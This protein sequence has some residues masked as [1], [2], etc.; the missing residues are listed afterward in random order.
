MGYQVGKAPGGWV[1]EQSA[2]R[3]RWIWF[4]LVIFVFLMLAMLALAV[5]GA[6]SAVASL[7]LIATLLT[8]RRYVDP[9]LDQ[10][11]RL[12]GGARAEEAVGVTLNELI[13]D[14]WTVMH[15]IEQPREGNVDHLVAGPGG[16][17]MVETK[18]RRY[19]E[20]Q[21]R[22]AKRQAAKIHDQLGVWVTPVICLHRRD[23][24]PR[25]QAG[26]WI[27]PHAHILNWLR[28]RRNTVVPFERLARF[29]D[30]V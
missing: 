10:H 12:L 27:V 20:W 19:E 5:G 7:L 9:Y 4:G 26:V 28:S 15:D 16:V 17:F 23:D 8:G 25:E 2:R 24:Q 18:A 1:R 13:R 29:A 3:A 11:L 21:L 6:L 14:G 30:S 22:K